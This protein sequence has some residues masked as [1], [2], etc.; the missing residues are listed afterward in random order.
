L[1][2]GLLPRLGWRAVSGFLADLRKL[3]STT[4][5]L[6]HFFD[7]TRM[8]YIQDKYG[9]GSLETTERFGSYYSQVADMRTFASF[10]SIK[11]TLPFATDQD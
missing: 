5:L 3:F 9:T 11:W 6:F 8:I 2:L 1:E 4:T 10:H 7:C